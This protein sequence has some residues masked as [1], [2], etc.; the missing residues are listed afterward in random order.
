MR[1]LHRL[2]GLLVGL[3]LL[4]LLSA[5]QGAAAASSVEALPLEIGNSWLYI[6]ELGIEEE[7]RITGTAI[8]GSEVTFV[9]DKVLGAIQFL[10]NDSVSGLRFHKLVIPEPQGG[11]IRFLP[12]QQGLPAQFDVGT[13]FMPAGTLSVTFTGLGTFSGSY[14]AISEVTAFEQ[15]IVP[16]GVFDAF[17]VDSTTV[18]SVDIFGDLVTSNQIDSVWYTIG[19][20]VVKQ[21]G[22][23][24]GS[25]F[26]IDLVSTNV[27]EPTVA[28]LLSL[29]LTAL[30]MARRRKTLVT[31]QPQHWR[32]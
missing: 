14:S 27:P 10:S 9:G 29:S 8:V 16:A 20:G 6:D 32:R 4:P 24:D 21:A 5:P 31:E 7:L 18:L 12:P 1:S 26:S 3:T 15:V 19:I 23:T 25:F 30:A 2:S 28:V 22:T 17:R 11:E 13:M